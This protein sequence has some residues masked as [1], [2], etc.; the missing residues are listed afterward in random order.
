MSDINDAIDSILKVQEML[1]AAIQVLDPR[2][3]NVTGMP[4]LNPGE[5]PSQDRRIGWAIALLAE[6][7]IRIEDIADLLSDIAG[8]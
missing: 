8:S 6:S 4:K 5:R 2:A 7:E 3:C 1:G